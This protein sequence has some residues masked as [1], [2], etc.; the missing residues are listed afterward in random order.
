[1]LKVLRQAWERNPDQRL[2]QLLA[3]AGRDPNRPAGDNFRDLFHVEDD[4]LWKGLEQIAG[5]ELD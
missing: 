4:E 5:G 3:N 2:G 1:M